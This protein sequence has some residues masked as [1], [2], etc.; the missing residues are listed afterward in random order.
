MPPISVLLFSRMKRSAEGWPRTITG[1]VGWE[2][3]VN[4]RAVVGHNCGPF[5]ALLPAEDRMASTVELPNSARTARRRF[6][7]ATVGTAFGMTRRRPHGGRD[8][9]APRRWLMPLIAGVPPQYGLYAAIV[10]TA[11]ASIFGS[12]GVFSSMGRQTPFRWS[13]SSPLLA[14]LSPTG[15]NGRLPKPCFYWPSWSGPSRLR[16]HCS[17]WGDLYPLHLR[18]SV[19]LWLHG[20]RPDWLTRNES[21]SATCLRSHGAGNGR[22]HLLHRLWENGS[23]RAVQSIHGSGGRLGR[24]ADCRRALPKHQQVSF[25]RASICCLVLIAAASVTH[26]LHWTLPDGTGLVAVVGENSGRLAHAAPAGLQA[27]LIRE[28][29][30]SRRRHVAAGIARV[31]IRN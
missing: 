6:A 2:I 1:C 8:R 10:V 5:A 21:E 12:S 31:A 23:N 14:F 17:G 16:S 26:F 20:G 29:G 19:V 27:R 18:E 7:L 25:G 11:V 9:H 30:G 22:Q 13:P 4:T 24:D 3:R 15:S 28:M